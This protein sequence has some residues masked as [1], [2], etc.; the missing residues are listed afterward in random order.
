MLMM[1]ITEP[2]SFI[3][4]IHRQI[5]KKEIQTTMTISTMNYGGL[6]TEPFI[7]S[8]QTLLIPWTIARCVLGRES[9]DAR[10]NYITN[11]EMT[12]IQHIFDALPSS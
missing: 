10:I 8:S 12:A 2:L 1:I 3:F 6:K 4:L 7:F 9:S 11:L 5:Q